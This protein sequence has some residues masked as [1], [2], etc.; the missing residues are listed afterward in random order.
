MFGVSKLAGYCMSSAPEHRQNL[1]FNRTDVKRFIFGT[2]CNFLGSKTPY[3]TIQWMDIT[4]AG[5]KS[6]GINNYDDQAI[7]RNERLLFSPPHRRTWLTRKSYGF[8]K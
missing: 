6:G 5:D 2:A 3:H 1:A 4:T 8:S 7:L